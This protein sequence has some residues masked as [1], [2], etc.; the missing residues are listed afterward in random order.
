MTIVPNQE[1]EFQGVY[2][3]HCADER[4]EVEVGRTLGI[5]SSYESWKPTFPPGFA[6]PGYLPYEGYYPAGL[7][8]R[9]RFI[10]TP[11]ESGSYGHRGCCQRRVIVGRVLDLKEA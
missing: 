8:F 1:G 11:G 10:G 7:A 9:I 5:F 6:A 3:A 4:I 2:L